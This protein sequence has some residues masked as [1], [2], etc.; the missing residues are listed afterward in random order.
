[1]RR[2]LQNSRELINEENLNDILKPGSS[3][4]KVIKPVKWIPSYY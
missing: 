4:L 3:G 1:M 2:I